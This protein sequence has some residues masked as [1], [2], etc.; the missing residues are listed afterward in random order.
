MKNILIFDLE[1][2]GHHTDYLLSLIRYLAKTDMKNSYII[3]TDSRFEN[4]YHEFKEKYLQKSPDNLHID[5][6][7]SR[8]LEKSK[9]LPLKHR[10]LW[11][12]ELY[13]QKL[14]EHKAS[15][16]I[17]MYFDLFQWGIFKGS[18]NEVPTAGILFRAK[19]GGNYQFGLT[20]KVKNKIA[21]YILQFSVKRAGIQKLF[22]LDKYAVKKYD[23]DLTNVSIMHLADPIMQFQK[24]Q[25]YEKNQLRENF[26]ITINQKVFLIFGFLDQRKGI[27]Q[28]ILALK[29]MPESEQKKITLLIA[30]PVALNLKEYISKIEDSTLHHFQ[31]IIKNQEFRNEDIQHLFEI[32]DLILALYQN[33]V[34]MSSVVVRAAISKKPIIAADYGMMGRYVTDHQLGHVVNPINTS[35]VKEVFSK[36]LSRDIIANEQNQSEVATANSADTFAA[37]ILSFNN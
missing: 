24:L 20:E 12:W 36:F 9:L 27:E 17:L 14:K 23:E 32:S 3:V 13:I 33:H 30:G 2:E 7:N 4:H 15:S 37:S 25:E 8:D 29:G 35:Q 11:E 1:T 26:G 10:S 31:L 34:G 22:L 6:I 21:H 16:G 18:K 28:V 5:Y 19:I